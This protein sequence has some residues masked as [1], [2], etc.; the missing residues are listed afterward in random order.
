MPRHSPKLR[1]KGFSAPWPTMPLGDCVLIT[2]GQS[3]LGKNYTNNPSDHILVQGNADLKN[4]YVIPRVWT[5]QVTKIASKGDL[6]MSVRAPV[7]DIGKTGYDIV[8]GRGVSAIKGNEF[9]FQLLTKLKLI[10]YWASV[11]YGSTFDSINSKDLSKT[12]I[13][14]PSLAEQTKIGEYFKGLDALIGLRQSQYD[15]LLSIKKACLAKMFPK[16]GSAKPQLRFKGFSDG[17]RTMS[18]SEVCEIIGGGTPNTSIAEYWGGDIAWFTPSEIGASKYIE[19][20]ERMISTQGLNNS[21]AKILPAGTILLTSRATIGEMSILK[22]KAA[23]NQGFQSLVVNNGYSNEYV[24]Y[25]QDK[26]K[27]QLLKKASGSTFLEISKSGLL[28]LEIPLPP[29]LAEQTKI[30]EYFKRLD[31]LISLRQVELEKLKNIKKACLGRM[32]I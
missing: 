15:K 3:P 32:F 9:I 14:L 31:H 10:G 16:R 26:I 28:G 11:S 12:I 22:T 18:L 4:G 19:R 13:P 7:G 29:S 27:K 23:T 6:I 17:W 30:G 1:F 2:M 24:Y 5:T 8:I 25:L 20:S 21:S